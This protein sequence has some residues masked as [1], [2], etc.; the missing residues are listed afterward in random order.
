MPTP[1]ISKDN[2][3]DSIPWASVVM[4]IHSCRNTIPKALDGLYRQKTPG[5]CEVIFVCDTI[6]DDTLEIIHNHPLAKRWEMVEISK[7]GRGLAEAYNII[8]LAG[9]TF[10]PCFLHAFGLLSGR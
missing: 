10:Q 7:P 5:R 8:W 1:E 3:D 2:A 6:K 9:G 4:P